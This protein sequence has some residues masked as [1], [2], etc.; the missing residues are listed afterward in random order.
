MRVLFCW[1]ICLH[2]STNQGAPDEHLHLPRSCFPDH[3]SRKI[4]K[5]L[6]VCW[7]SRKI[8]QA[9]NLQR[10]R[11]VCTRGVTKVVC[12]GEQIQIPETANEK[13]FYGKRTYGSEVVSWMEHEARQRGVHIHHQMC[14]DYRLSSGW[15]LPGNK[16]GVSV[17]RAPLPWLSRV[18]L[19]RVKGSSRLWKNQLRKTKH[20]H[21][22][23][24]VHE[25]WK[26]K[27][28]LKQA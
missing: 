2:A 11:E 25:C 22:R 8:Y 12:Q 19:K 6:C 16:H 24:S 20:L 26:V 14:G 9:W 27:Q 10:H 5:P 3:K 18:F 13:A 4:V 21:K 15:F 17:A 23:Y 28:F 7:V 1:N